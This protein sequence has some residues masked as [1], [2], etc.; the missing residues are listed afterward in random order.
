MSDREQ[1]AADEMVR[2]Q[3]LEK[4]LDGPMQ[5]GDPDCV[6]PDCIKEEEELYL[7]I[8]P[9]ATIIQHAFRNFSTDCNR[10]GVG[11]GDHSPGCKC[12]K[13]CRATRTAVKGD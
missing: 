5:C 13:I 1:C 8:P 7:H 12:V 9:T 2:Q 4:M 11:S 10:V 6:D 3:L